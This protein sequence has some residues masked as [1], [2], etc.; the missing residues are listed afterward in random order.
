[1]HEM[2]LIESIMRIVMDERERHGLSR[3][4]RVTLENGAL[5][6]AVTDA[7]LFAWQ[8]HTRDTDLA[9]TT[10]AIVEVPLQV[11]CGG[12]GT[13]FKPEDRY[14]M[15]CPSC[16]LEI[17]HRVLAGRELRITGIEGD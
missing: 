6:G 2:S 17:G 10:L 13:E 14:W 12:C 9:D 7:L 5:A 16:G 3:I 4:T 11:A 1:M 8:A 15:P